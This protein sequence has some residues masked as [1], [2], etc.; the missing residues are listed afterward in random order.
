MSG[1]DEHIDRMLNDL[2]DNYVLSEDG[3][4]AHLLSFALE[5]QMI[6]SNR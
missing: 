3:S 6:L 4:L 2:E 1:A 5:Q